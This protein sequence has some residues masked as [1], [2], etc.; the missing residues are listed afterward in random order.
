MPRAIRAVLIAATGFVAIGSHPA[1]QVHRPHNIVLFVPDGLRALIVNQQIAP[2][3]AAIRDRGVNFKNPHSLFPTFTTANA[4]AMATGHY[5]GDTGNFSN[6][7]Y[8]GFTV[9]SLTASVT[10]FLEHDVALGI[11]VATIWMKRRFSRRRGAR[12]FARQPWESSDRRSSSTIP[13][14]PAIRRSSSTIRRGNP[15]AFP[16]LARCVER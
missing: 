6:T 15:L 16:F 14:G 13:I 2:T 1:G 4:S 3:L 8:A 10:P 5:F 9:R 11:S 7:I 12:D